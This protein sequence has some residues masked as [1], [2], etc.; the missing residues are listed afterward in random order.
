MTIK[1]LGELVNKRFDAL[2]TRMKS[3]ESSRDFMKG[4]WKTLTVFS[5]LA[6]VIMGIIIKIKLF[7]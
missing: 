3:L 6:V 2:D 7:P 5:G 1:E 4:V